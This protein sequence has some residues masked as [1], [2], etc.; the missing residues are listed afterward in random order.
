[1]T[2]KLFVA[3]KALLFHQE[4]LLLIRESPRYKEGSQI[5]KFDVIGGRVEPGQPFNESLLR[6]I[7]EETGLDAELG[8]PFF[9]N[10]VRPVV[11]GEPWQIIRIFFL[12]KSNS[13][14]VKLSEDHDA[15][16]WI[17][18]KNYKNHNIIENLHPVFEEYLKNE[19]T[20]I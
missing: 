3:V 17:D 5:G 20:N 6:E 14:D 13:F 8:V 1:M 16:E 10:E 4:K 11:K 18:P 9:V 2:P 15:Y 7:K 19:S 12:C